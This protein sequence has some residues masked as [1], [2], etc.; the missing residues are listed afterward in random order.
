M[1]FNEPNLD[2][3]WK[4]IVGCWSRG[5]ITVQ[6][7]ENAFYTGYKTHPE[8][9]KRNQPRSRSAIYKK[10][11]NPTQLSPFF[12][13]R[14]FRCLCDLLAFKG[15][16]DKSSADNP[17][18][19]T[20]VNSN[21]LLEDTSTI[22]GYFRTFKP[23]IGKCGYVV[24]G[25]MR[26]SINENVLQTYEILRYRMNSAQK[27]MQKHTY[28]GTLYQE[29]EDHFRIQ[30]LDS[31]TQCHNHW[32]LRPLYRNQEGRIDVLEGSYS[33][34]TSK[35]GGRQFFS[36]KVYMERVDISDK[37]PIAKQ[38]IKTLSGY[39]HIEPGKSDGEID[40]DIWEKVNPESS[41]NL[42]IY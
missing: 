5:E 26:I 13:E 16:T 18:V 30:S 2:K 23:S 40:Y 11:K 8:T 34:I 36:A 4:K 29:A 38:L 10:L 41:Q 20:I 32:L 24:S 12:D 33:G 14:D 25:L 21:H 7:I 19:S 35:R 27:R 28:H 3:V 1:R 39:K 31:S 37:F 42:V 17:G 22:C 15:K 6:E 9:S